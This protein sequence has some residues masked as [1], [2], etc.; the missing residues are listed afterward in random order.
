MRRFT[1]A[2]LVL[3][4]MLASGAVETA[5]AQFY[6]PNYPQA[7]PNYPQFYPSYPGYQPAAIN[8]NNTGNNRQTMARPAVQQPGAV[9]IAATG[10]NLQ[11]H[12]PGAG[13]LQNNGY[14]GL[15][16][17]GPGNTRGTNPPQPYFYAQNPSV[18]GS[19][20]QYNPG[21]LGTPSYF[22][23][24]SYNSSGFGGSSH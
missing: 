2:G 14:T 3:L 22:G 10:Q 8:R 19:L 18:G 7:Y 15:N 6:P 9:G 20:G 17:Q 16:G 1:G 21:Y 23:Q 4:T 5:Q 13:Y 24:S 12:V 11:N